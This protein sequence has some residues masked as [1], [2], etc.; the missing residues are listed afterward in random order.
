MITISWISHSISFFASDG[1]KKSVIRAVNC[2]RTVQKTSPCTACTSVRSI[3]RNSRDD[4][5]QTLH[6][7]APLSKV[8]NKSL[9]VSE[10]SEL[11][12]KQQKLLAELQGMKSV[13]NQ[14]EVYVPDE[15]HGELHEFFTMAE[16]FHGQL[17]PMV[18]LFWEQQALAFKASNRGKLFLLKCKIRYTASYLLTR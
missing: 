8:K 1:T 17:Q 13:I 6:P 11:R 15:V 4:K 5:V 7:N 3:F 18:Q 2:Q 14:Q 10:V 9:L 12:N 16:K